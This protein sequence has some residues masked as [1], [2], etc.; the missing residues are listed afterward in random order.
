MKLIFILI[1]QTKRKWR[2]IENTKDNK[3]GLPRRKEMILKL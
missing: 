3:K 2:K 1:N